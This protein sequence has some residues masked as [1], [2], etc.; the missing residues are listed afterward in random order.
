[1][2]SKEMAVTLCTR[3]L[4]AFSTSES[5]LQ[6]LFFLSFFPSIPS[7][8]PDKTHYMLHGFI[9]SVDIIIITP[10]LS[11]QSGELLLHKLAFA[12]SSLL[13]CCLARSYMLA[14]ACS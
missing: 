10:C 9:S 5:K 1:M 4:M 7:A 13:V 12:Y 11:I 2:H 14:L 6:S 8:C 3:E